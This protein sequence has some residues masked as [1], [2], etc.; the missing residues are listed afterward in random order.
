MHMKPCAMRHSAKL[1]TTPNPYPRSDHPPDAGRCLGSL[2]RPVWVIQRLGRAPFGGVATDKPGEAASCRCPDQVGTRCI[3]KSML[4][5]GSLSLAHSLSP[6]SLSPSL[7]LSLSHTHT[8]LHRHPHM[9]MPPCVVADTHTHTHTCTCVR[10]CVQTHTHTHTHTHTQTT[11]T[12]HHAHTYR[13]S[14]G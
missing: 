5:R 9:Y 2:G 13:V 3:E 14:R 1:L 6:P 11:H 12:P 7:S 10:E 4:K 8:H